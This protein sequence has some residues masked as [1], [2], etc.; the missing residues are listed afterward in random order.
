MKR[1]GET[2]K[3]CLL[4]KYKNCSQML[5]QTHLT[6]PRGVAGTKAPLQIFAMVFTHGSGYLPWGP[7]HEK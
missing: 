2:W 6:Y 7:P 3:K 1:R 5:L 4:N